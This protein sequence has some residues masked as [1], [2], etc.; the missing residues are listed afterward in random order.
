MTQDND[1]STVMDTT[2]TEV[3]S[4][5]E[6]TEASNPSIDGNGRLET[7]SK[8]D[9]GSS[10]V[11]MR[12]AGEA[13]EIDRNNTTS[14]NFAKHVQENSEAEQNSAREPEPLQ[15][16]LSS[17]PKPQSKQDT[18]ADYEEFAQ[19][20]DVQEVIENVLH[21]LRWALKAEDRESDGEQVD[22]ISR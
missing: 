18:R 3:T 9:D 11:T 16:G 10:D 12:D 19:Q 13:S 20:Q 17:T 15:K 2:M 7:E 4:D 22:L 6:M 14:S 8:D 5:G 21:Q 1:E